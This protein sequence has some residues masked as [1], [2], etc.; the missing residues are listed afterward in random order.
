MATRFVTNIGLLSL[1]VLAG[2]GGGSP[3]ANALATT[4]G[5]KTTDGTAVAKAA[6]ANFQAAFDSF[7]AHDRANDWN[8]ANCAQVAKAF[9][10][11]VGEQPNKKFAEAHYNAGLSYQRCDN[12]KEAKEAFQKSLGDDPKFHH[13]QAAL[14]LYKFK[15]D[16][17]IDAAIAALEDVVTAAQFQ[18]VPALVNLAMLQIER[19]SDKIGANCKTFAGSG[20]DRKEV[21]LKDFEC[22]KLNLQRGLAIDDSYMP[23][24]N[25]LALYY[26]KGAKKRA[27][28]KEA[29]LAEKAAKAG[30]EK[31]PAKKVEKAKANDKGVH[32]V[33]AAK[34]RHIDV[35]ALELAALVCS[36]AI[37][38]NPKYAPIYNTLGLISSEL[39]QINGAVTA[40]QKAVTLDSHFFEAQMNLAAVNLSYRGFDRA[41]QAYQKALEFKPKDYEAHLG[42]AL[43]LRGQINET[44]YDKQI[45]AVQ[46]E[47]DQC[48]SIDANRPDAYFNEAILT[49]EYK[50]NSGGG[51]DKTLVQLDAAEALYKTFME[52]AGDNPKYAETSKRAKDRIED[53]GTTRQFLKDSAAAAA[54]TPP[55][56]APASAAPG[57]APDNQP[58]PAP[59][60]GQPVPAPAQPPTA[61]H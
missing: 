24:F 47:L 15:D 28:A 56:T 21:E 53:I 35:Q 23:A 51:S 58:A 60:P 37:R 20:K 49:Q 19:D 40:F 22:A 14:T 9:E 27:T 32:R 36:Q 61:P 52:K 45:S 4:T 13:A 39:G 2:C 8:D 7:L 48:K 41:Q 46:A 5:P 34:E 57:P 44:N 3:A 31:K 42:M 25:Q 1:F 50:A 18:N 26:F 12:D 54:A 29:A 10:D 11:A 38:K 16:N 30:K 43:A 55:P 33:V 17:N 6:A 59:A